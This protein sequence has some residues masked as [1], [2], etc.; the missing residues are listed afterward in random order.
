MGYLYGKWK[1]HWQNVTTTFTLPNGLKKA[2]KTLDKR[3]SRCYNNK[4]SL[5]KQ[6]NIRYLGV[7]QLGSV[8]EWGSRGREFESLHPDACKPL[9]RNGFKGFLIPK[10]PNFYPKQ[11]ETTFSRHEKKEAF[12]PSF[13]LSAINLLPCRQESIRRNSL[14]LR[15]SC[16]HQ[17]FKHRI[18]RKI[19]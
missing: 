4:R 14:C 19:L 7:A 12:A 9:C 3:A 1:Q 15:R 16:F 11:N 6:T 18:E 10:Y 17:H 2:E 5:M 8:L 13:L